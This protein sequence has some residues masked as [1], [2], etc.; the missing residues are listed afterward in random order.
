MKPFFIYLVLIGW[1]VSAASLGHA[2]E[3]VEPVAEKPAVEKGPRYWSTRWVF[4]D[5][6]VGQLT[7]RLSSIGID[8]GVPL[9]GTV[10]VKFN[11]G[12]PWTSPRDAAA[13]RFEGTLTSPELMIDQVQLQNVQVDIE[14]RKGTATLTRLQAEQP[15]G[16]PATVGPFPVVATPAGAVMADEKRVGSIRGSGSVELVPRGDASGELHLENLDLTTIAKWISNLRSGTVSADVEL[17]VPLESISR[18]ETYRMT[19]QA[20]GES[21]VLKGLPPATFDVS[22]ISILDGILQLDYFDLVATESGAEGETIR[23]QGTAS[24][25]LTGDRKFAME[26]AADD[27]PTAAVA[28]LI[29]ASEPIVQGK[30]DFRGS[31][32]GQISEPLTKSQWE[33]VGSV[34]SP[35]LSVGGVDLGVIEHDIRFTKS[36]L[37]IH[38]CRSAESLPGS[39]KIGSIQC[40]YQISDNA[41]SIDRLDAGLWGGRFTG[42]A[43]L[44]LEST[45]LAQAEVEFSGIRPVAALPLGMIASPKL[46]A[47]LGGQLKWQVP[48]ESLDRPAAHRGTARI[49]LDDCKIGD[50][51]LGWIEVSVTASEDELS[52]EGDGEILDGTLRVRTVAA[53]M[54]DD[55]WKDLSRRLQRSEFQFDDLSIHRGISMSP[56][57]DVPL[58][59]RISGA[60]TGV[61]FAGADPKQSSLRLELD[62]DGLRYR[63]IPLSKRTSL[64]GEFDGE[65]VRLESFVGD[66]AGGSVRV[67][68]RVPLYES[69]GVLNPRV[70]LAMRADRIDL[71]RGLFFVSALSDQISGKVSGSARLSGSQQ[72]FRLR[73]RLNADSL[74]VSEFPLGA[75]HSDLRLDFDASRLKWKLNLPAIASNV[76]GG[77]LDGELAVSSHRGKTGV[78]LASRWKTRQ[79]DLFR[80]GQP[81]GGS[82][83]R[84][85]GQVTG[86]LNL[87]GKAVSSVDD[88]AGR[89]D[90]RLGKTQGAAVPGLVGI[91]RFL[92]PI[93]LATEKF[94]TGAARG[95]IGNGVVTIDEFWMGSDAALV[96]ADGQ[97]YL[98]TKRLNFDAIIATGDYG[99]IALDFQQL[100]EDY[101]LRTFLP[102]SAILDLS[103]LLR[104]RT[105]VV[106]IRGTSD[107]PIV[108][109]QPV[110]TF[111]EEA[112]RFLLR[113]GRRLILTG[114]TAG[115][116]EGLD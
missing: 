39:V 34:A 32:R 9:D 78:D 12:V 95:V 92:G 82:Q 7:A 6:D 61:L 15:A 47:T 36:S 31:A 18:V 72:Q 88:L 77:W 102:A 71:S 14:Y 41:L 17:A 62:L 110:E 56:Y 90:F 96:Q 70:N 58:R 52:L 25:G 46:S 35:G 113:E 107:R 5:I 87:G 64:R 40:E 27:L 50:E 38:P 100:I 76:G 23:L 103:E 94:D 26:V 55:R 30:L 11:V 66:Y 80:L 57:H 4:E 42:S 83:S 93:S 79:V 29:S 91:S 16:G 106:K 101:V 75:A 53:A 19:G 24:L 48:I 54:P 51:S 67:S 105:V 8:V 49:R 22:K 21:V 28:G 37:T 97:L 69:D 112:A 109:L 33:I 89:F 65:E 74:V 115:A 13:Y 73:G 81:H 44:P 63:D 10:S 43:R 98:R 86:E 108:Q 68:G 1:I 60:V 99:D 84:A 2:Q 114:I 111:R 116:I 59:G 104:D 20:H 85:T 45:G 3:K